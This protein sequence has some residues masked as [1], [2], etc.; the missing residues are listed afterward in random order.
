[1][2]YGIYRGRKVPLE[3]PIREPKPYRKEMKVYVM[4]PK[5]GQIN[6][7]RYGDA[8]LVLKSHIPARKKSYCSRTK[9]LSK[10]G[11]KLSPNYWSRKRWGC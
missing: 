9:N 3:K 6:L 1:M 7:V 8:D 10:K 11:D 5:T 2:R 4:N